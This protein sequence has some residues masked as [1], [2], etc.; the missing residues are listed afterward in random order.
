MEAILPCFF[1]FIFDNV[2]DIRRVVKIGP[3]VVDG[4]IISTH[5]WVPNT[6]LDDTL[7]TR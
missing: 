1:K 4:F 5:P 7:S 3:W 2:K 6:L